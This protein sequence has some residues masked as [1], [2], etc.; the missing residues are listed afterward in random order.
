MSMAMLA[1]VSAEIMEG[2]TQVWASWRLAQSI[3]M[4]LSS[5]ATII[6][7]AITIGYMGL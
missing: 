7:S 5:K 1:V 6:Q 2:I 4:E 3:T